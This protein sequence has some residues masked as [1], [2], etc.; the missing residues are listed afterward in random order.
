MAEAQSLCLF[1]PGTRAC[2]ACFIKL[3]M[4]NNALRALFHITS[5]ISGAAPPREHPAREDEESGN[6]KL[7][8]VVL[9]GK[10]N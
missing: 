3:V 7:S 8:I 2:S 9:L 1:W 10:H 6:Q 5:L 4:W